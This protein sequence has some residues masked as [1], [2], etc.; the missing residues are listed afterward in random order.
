[1]IQPLN[2]HSQRHP[3]GSIPLH[4]GEAHEGQG[5]FKASSGQAAQDNDP[6][7]ERAPSARQ[8]EP[9]VPHAGTGHAPGLLHLRLHREG[10]CPCTCRSAAPNASPRP[11]RAVGRQPPGRLRQ[12]PGRGR[13]T[14]CSRPGDPLPR[15][16]AQLRGRRMRHPR[17]GGPVRPPPPAWADREHPASAAPPGPAGLR[18]PGAAQSPAAFT[19]S[20]SRLGDLLQGRPVRLSCHGGCP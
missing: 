9:P 20:S 7:Q 10:L 8:G 16:L 15:T 18:R 14:A 6:G 5:A 13:S 1:M 11:D 12:R 4:D 19:A 2:T 3:V 17:T